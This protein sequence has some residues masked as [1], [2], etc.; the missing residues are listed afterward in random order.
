MGR[1][2]KA[3]VKQKH[4]PAT[5]SIKKSSKSSIKKIKDFERCKDWLIEQKNI[6]H[7]SVP[8]HDINDEQNSEYD[9]EV[10]RKV[11]REEKPKVRS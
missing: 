5:R 10:C 4:K 7:Q 9:N 3:V 6:P 8:I 11:D 2:S 1:R